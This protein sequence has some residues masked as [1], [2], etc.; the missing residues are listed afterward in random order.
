VT[1]PGRLVAS[2]R[3]GDIYEFGPGLV[4]R[5]TKRDRVI[6]HEARV[7]AYAAEHGYPVPAV[8]EVRAGGTEIV[9]ERLDGPMMMDQMIR[10]PQTFMRNTRRLADLHD[11]LHEI[12]AP[13]W[14]PQA[15]PGNETGRLLHLDLHPMN[16]MVTERGPVVIDWTNAA[17]GEP[18][19]DVGLTYV[20][21]TCAEGPMSPLLRAVLRPARALMARGFANRYRG[22]DLNEHV[23]YA[24]ELK[25]LDPA[26][27]PAE[28][29]SFRQLA[30]RMRVNP[31]PGGN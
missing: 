25:M 27:A 12:P 7:M 29:E 19:T 28:V 10:Q 20:L 2:G 3:D 30:A 4:L 1:E 18:L 26:M 24:A 13:D 17:R 31:G 8:H 5:R 6:E 21:L 22:P 9:M 23:A 14:L 11:Q 15:G 16:V